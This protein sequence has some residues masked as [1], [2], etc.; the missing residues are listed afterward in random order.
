MSENQQ[1]PPRLI[2]GKIEAIVRCDDEQIIV[3]RDENDNEHRIVSVK[4]QI[5]L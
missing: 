3:L 2:G 5:H 1:E 4:G